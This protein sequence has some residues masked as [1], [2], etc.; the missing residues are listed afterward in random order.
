MSKLGRRIKKLT[1]EAILGIFINLFPK[2]RLFDHIYSAVV[3]LITHKRLPRS[4]LIFNDVLYS[5]KI[6]DEILDPL[7]VFVSDKEFVKLYIAAIVGD[8]YNVPSIAVLRDRRLISCFSFPPECCIKPTHLSGR[9]VFR[10][11]NQDIDL[12]EI[13]SWFNINFYTLSREANYRRLRPKVI[14]EPLIFSTVN[15]VDFKF[16]CYCGVAKLI[17]VDVDRFVNHRRKF[18]DTTWNELSFSSVYKRYEGDI[19]KPDNLD[20]MLS[21]ASRLSERF[22]FVRIDMYSDNDRV[23]VGEITNCSE[24]ACAVFIPKSGEILASA[25][26]FS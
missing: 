14:I 21:I 7:R 10:K 16:F 22:S 24:S 1:R 3:F 15:P 17:Q 25:L 8:K 13:D 6:G 19:A 5:L 9:A 12:V 26:I 2:N 18:F 4:A 20:E 11:A 23:L